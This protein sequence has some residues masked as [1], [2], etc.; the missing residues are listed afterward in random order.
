MIA[1][2]VS[3]YAPGDPLIEGS[4]GVEGTADGGDGGGTP[5]LTYWIAETTNFSQSTVNTCTGTSLNNVGQHL[6]ARLIDDD[7]MGTYRLNGETD[8]REFA[9]STVLAIGQDNIAAD[10]VAL[11][12]YAGHGQVN[13][14]QWG[15]PDP[16]A[17]IN[18]CRLTPSTQMRLGT[19][20]GDVARLS[21][22]IT[23]CTLNVPNLTAT[24]G[25]SRAGQYLGWHNSPAVSDLMA[26]SFYE[27]TKFMIE[28]GPPLTNRL[29]W[30]AAGKSK[31]GLAY[32]SP[33]IFSEQGE[34]ADVQWRHFFARVSAGTGVDED[35]PEAPANRHRFTWLDYGECP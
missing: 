16:S 2:L 6:Q 30:L 24:V 10:T 28:D 31:P 8:R 32:N 20:N 3:C 34:D 11:A 23:S 13:S 9:D 17:L 18:R 12:V 25:I 22:F 33:V 27:Q 14:V 29:S 21:I 4:E 26:S 19:A 1:L 35:I 15:N 7:W 5:L